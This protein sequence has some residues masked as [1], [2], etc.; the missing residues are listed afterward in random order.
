MCGLLGVSAAAC[1]VEDVIRGSRAGT[2]GD[3]SLWHLLLFSVVPSANTM[4][5]YTDHFIIKNKW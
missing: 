5:K 4:Q 2:S 1:L 3:A